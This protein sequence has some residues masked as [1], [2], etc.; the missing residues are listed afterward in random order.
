MLAHYYKKHTLIVTFGRILI[1][2]LRSKLAQGNSGSETTVNTKVTRGF[3]HR[4]D[5]AIFRCGRVYRSIIII[6][7]SLLSL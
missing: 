2:R 5:K 3:E 6:L 7:L 4:I 1:I